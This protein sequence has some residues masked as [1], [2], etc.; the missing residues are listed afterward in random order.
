MSTED[1]TGGH[2]PRGEANR[3]APP[4]DG[5]PRGVPIP[6]G[7]L[8]PT[9]EDLAIVATFERWLAGDRTEWDD[10]GLPYVDT[11]NPYAMCGCGHIW[12]AHDIEEYTGDGS[13]TCCV[14]GCPQ[15]GCPGRRQA[16]THVQRGETS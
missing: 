16:V 1:G 5:A 8:S 6:C 13:E 11:S 15:T 2:A 12:M 14:V 9:A 4:L 10:R 3:P 7:P